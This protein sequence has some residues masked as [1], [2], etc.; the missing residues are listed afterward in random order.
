MIYY[1]SGPVTV[2]EPGLAVIECAGVGYGCRVTAYTAAQLK[3][4][5][6]ARLYVTESIREDAFDLYGFISREEQQCYQLLTSVNGVGPK[7]A[8]AILAAG[9][10]NFTLAVMTGDEKL[11]TAAQ[12]VGKKIAQRIILELKDK[13]GGGSMEIDFSAGPAVAAPAQQ[14][15]AALANAALQELGY[16]AAEIAQALKGVD[17]K[18]ST[19][20]MVRYALRA[21][22]MKS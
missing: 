17:P 13:I 12:G 4:N 21:M 2:L 9:P 6:N 20:D 19:E 22:V 16:S 11:L 5:Q 8:M 10:Q 14:G 1:V 15:N 7:A 3:L 18:A